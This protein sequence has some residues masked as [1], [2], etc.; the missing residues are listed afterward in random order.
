MK[1]NL[2]RNDLDLFLDFSSDRLHDFAALR[3]KTLFLRQGML[4][5]YDLN[6]LRENVPCVARLSVAGMSAH[7]N[8][9]F[10]RLAGLSS[11][12]FRLVEKET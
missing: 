2:R 1:N 9:G 12:D 11:I 8:C 10:F 3:A 6:I 7:F 5:L 4:H